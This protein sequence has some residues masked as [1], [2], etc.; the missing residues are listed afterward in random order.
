M[1]LEVQF[2][3]KGTGVGPDEV[4]ESRDVK[5]FEDRTNR[6]NSKTSGCVQLYLRS[7]LLLFS[8][9]CLGSSQTAN[10]PKSCCAMEM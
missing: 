2:V 4:K 1:G 7:S 3:I 8:F 9:F 10:K 6:R 5:G